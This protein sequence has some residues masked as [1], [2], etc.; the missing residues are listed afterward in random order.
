MPKNLGILPNTL[1]LSCLLIGEGPGSVRDP[2]Q[3]WV[4]GRRGR[5]D[6]VGSDRGRRAGDVRA[7]R[8]VAV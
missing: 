7:G 1:V 2:G 5:L 4:G 6:G 8:D 3:A